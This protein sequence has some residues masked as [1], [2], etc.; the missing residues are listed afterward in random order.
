MTVQAEEEDSVLVVVVVVVRRL[1]VVVEA[2]VQRLLM[3]AA[4]DLSLLLLAWP[5]NTLHTYTHTLICA[6]AHSSHTPMPMHAVIQRSMTENN[7]ASTN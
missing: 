2:A 1:L 4:V 5:E 3:V 6:H 7:R